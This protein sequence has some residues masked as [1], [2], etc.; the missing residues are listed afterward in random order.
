MKQPQA[1]DSL[2][3][4]VKNASIQGHTLIRSHIPY[5]KHDGDDD[6]DHNEMK[7]KME[8]VG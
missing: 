4:A 7:M 5:I 2:T 1:Q 3:A 6:K 8:N